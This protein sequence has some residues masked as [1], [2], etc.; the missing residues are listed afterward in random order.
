MDQKL[1]G[2][3]CHRSE[4]ALNR[5]SLFGKRAVVD[6]FDMIASAYP[7]FHFPLDGVRSIDAQ[8]LGWDGDKV[9]AR[10]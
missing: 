1:V 2:H 5:K 7:L 8:S 6:C 3:S 10:R 9:G 4:S